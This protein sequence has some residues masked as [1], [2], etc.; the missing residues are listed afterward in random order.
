MVSLSILIPIYNVEQ[1]LS[2]CLDSIL[3]RNRFKSEVICV[4]DGSTDRCSEIL[5]AYSERYPNIKIIR[6]QNA[7]LSAA[8]NTALKNATGDYVLFVDS[9][10][11]LADNSIETLCSKLS[12]EDVLYYNVQ[13]FYDTTKER[14][15]I[16]PLPEVKNMN[17][18]TY[19]EHFF[20][21]KNYMPC[22]CVWAAVYRRYFLLE[23]NLYNKDGIT[24]E[25]EEFYPRVLYYAKSVSTI[26]DVLY[27]Y[28]LRDG[29]IMRSAS[30]KQRLDF[31]K[32]A[33]GLV[34]FFKEKEWINNT[35]LNAA[36]YI[37]ICMI[38]YT[39]EHS[40]K[41]PKEYNITQLRK[42]LS[43][44]TTIQDRRTTLL[45]AVSFNL[46]LKYHNY[47]LPKYQRKLINFILH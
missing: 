41:R 33:S 4:D 43:C 17:G 28:R 27:F 39:V 26:N 7:G 9:D 32:V 40:L 30:F 6:Q 10:D 35:T 24:H 44:S 18:K 3:I 1:Y 22:V 15:S 46:A 37:Y 34:D 31:I 5:T 42:M 16:A 12:G 45:S 29:G 23:N 13:R 21:R 14:L 36:F 2:E 8:R 11:Y 38:Y 19:Y 25:D 47:T 20:N